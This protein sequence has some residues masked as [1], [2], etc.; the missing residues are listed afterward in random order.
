MFVLM[1]FQRTRRVRVDGNPVSQQWSE[2]E[3]GEVVKQRV[4]RGLVDINWPD[5]G[6]RTSKL[7]LEEYGGGPDDG[8]APTWVFCRKI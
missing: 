8:P 3:L 7:N 1:R 4:T 2:W 6:R 5:V